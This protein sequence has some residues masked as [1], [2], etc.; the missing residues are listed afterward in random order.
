[1]IWPEKI[2]GDPMPHYRA[3][4]KPEQADRLWLWD[5]RDACEEKDITQSDDA[6][7]GWAGVHLADSI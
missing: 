3:S 6:S 5:C 7:N 2:C 1:M 4:V